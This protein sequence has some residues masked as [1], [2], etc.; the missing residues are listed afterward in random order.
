MY[1]DASVRLFRNVHEERIQ[2]F[3][4]EGQIG[5]HC[6]HHG[7]HYFLVQEQCGSQGHETKQSSHHA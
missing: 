1:F 6:R 5:V 3:V 2:R 4:G 7:W